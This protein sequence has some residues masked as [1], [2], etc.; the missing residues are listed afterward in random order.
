[1]YLRNNLHTPDVRQVLRSLSKVLSLK[2][3]HTQ[4]HTNPPEYLPFEEHY[5]TPLAMLDKYPAIDP[6]GLIHDFLS[7]IFHHRKLSAECGVVAVVYIDRLLADPQ[8]EVTAANWCLV[9]FV[10]LLLAHKVWAEYAV[11]NEDFVKV[12]PKGKWLTVDVVRKIER[13]FLKR[14]NFNLNVKPSVY[15]RYYFELRTFAK[16]D[17]V[18]YCPMDKQ[19]LMELEVKRR[20]VSRRN[21]SVSTDSGVENQG[22]GTVSFDQLMAVRKE[23]VLSIVY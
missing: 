2:I 20:C 15:S 12:F 8:L 7:R 16:L 6:Y 4:A 23:I 3:K 13:E 11:W 5:Y 10:A 21:R 1:M 22:K 18:D 17:N 14:I 19:T 9:V